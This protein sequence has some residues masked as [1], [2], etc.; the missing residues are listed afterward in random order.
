M[1]KKKA[2]APRG[3]P[4]LGHEGHPGRPDRCDACRLRKWREARGLTQAEAAHLIP[5]GRSK[6]TPLRTYHRWERGDVGVPAIVVA[7]LETLK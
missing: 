3:R 5:G 7:F 4:S 6:H 1:E 2:A